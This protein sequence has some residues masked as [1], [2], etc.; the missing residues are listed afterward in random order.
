MFNSSNSE[1]KKQPPPQ[2]KNL[3]GSSNRSFCM[4][5]ISI[6]NM[7]LI[8]GLTQWV[9]VDPALLWLWHRLAAAVV[10]RPLAWELPYAIGAALKKKRKKN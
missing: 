7:G 1:K 9:A 10:I 6:E 2:K 5:M 8:P 4:V 3:K